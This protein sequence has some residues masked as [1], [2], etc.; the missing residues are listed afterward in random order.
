MQCAIA[1]WQGKQNDNTAISMSLQLVITNEP[2]NKREH[3]RSLS[4][5]VIRKTM[6]STA[7]HFDLYKQNKKQSSRT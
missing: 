7:S 4:L 3:F 5:S 6:N 1:H 2:N